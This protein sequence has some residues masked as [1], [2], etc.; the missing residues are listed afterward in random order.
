[1]IPKVIH[2]CWFGHH[3]L[4][5][6]AITCIESWKHFCP[7]YK[8]M[9]WDESNF[10]L[11]SCPYV[12]EAYAEKRWAFVSDYARLKIIY[13]NGGIYLDT[14][15]ELLKSF[16]DLIS[17]SCFLGT[18]IGKDGGLVNT[19]VGFGAEKGH[20][21]VKKMLDEYQDIHYKGS[22]GITDST[23]CPERNTT[24]LAKLGFVYQKEIWQRDRV[25]VF[26][27]EYFSPMNY[28]TGE[29]VVT[30][31]SYSIHHYSA[32]WISDKDREM[33]KIIEDLEMKYPKPI[34]QAKKQWILYKKLKERG[35]T[36][37]F[38]KFLIAKI[39]L[40][41]GNMR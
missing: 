9:L 40:K 15:V 33:I 8:I 7:D 16:D 34:A 18:E 39:R 24:A 37:N 38:V 30:E 32:L 1:M 36:K 20:E 3:P 12:T 22:N 4:P 35:K 13:E 26:P 19:G 14:D 27:P 29:T 25:Y 10:D 5:D 23:T 6:L 31:K 21:V 11:T 2:Y 28:I 41:L 17:Y